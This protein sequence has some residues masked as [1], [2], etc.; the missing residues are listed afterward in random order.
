MKRCSTSQIIR[1]VQVEITVSCHCTSVRVAINKKKTDDKRC[2]DVEKRKHLYA[3]GGNVNCCS[4]YGNR[5][6]GF[7]KNEK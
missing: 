7:S 1:E 6:G 3:V 5:N 2:Q 4:H